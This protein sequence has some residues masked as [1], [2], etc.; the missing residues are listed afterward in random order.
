MAWSTKVN[1]RVI[2]SNPIIKIINFFIAILDFFT[3]V[4]R[5]GVLND[6]NNHVVINTNT[7]ILWF[8]PYAKQTIKVAK[9]NISAIKVSD[10]RSL[11]IF[12]SIIV[13]FFAS[14]TETTGNAYEVKCS[15]DEIKG[16]ADLWI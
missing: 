3:G 5:S 8:F 4:R 13:Q 10:E 9:K 2:G 14:G 16:K 1:V 15:Y 6:E 12:K 11:I 7:K